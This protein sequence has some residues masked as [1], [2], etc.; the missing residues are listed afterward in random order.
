MALHL[1]VSGQSVFFGSLSTQHRQAGRI[2]AML[3]HPLFLK[4][5]LVS[6]SNEE[7]VRSVISKDLKLEKKAGSV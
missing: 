3:D 7:P 2:S 4:D 5:G 6:D 1:L